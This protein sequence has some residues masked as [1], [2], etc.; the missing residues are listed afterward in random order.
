[1]NVFN[2]CF[3]I[4]TRAHTCVSTTNCTN[5]VAE[6]DRFQVL[7]YSKKKKKNG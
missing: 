4:V 5:I 2:N 1:M 3:E 7:I 6:H